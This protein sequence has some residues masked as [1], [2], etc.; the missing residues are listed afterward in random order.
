MDN[1]AVEEVAILRQVE[2]YRF[3]I[4]IADDDEIGL[5]DF[6]QEILLPHE[7]FA[8]LFEHHRDFCPADL[9]G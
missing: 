5:K 6:V 2:T 8:A 3:P 9:R 7:V 4:P 1:L